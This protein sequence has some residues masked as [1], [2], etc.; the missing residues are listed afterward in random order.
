M[1]NNWKKSLKQILKWR[2]CDHTSKNY[3]NS[4]INYKESSLKLDVTRNL[5]S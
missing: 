3:K 1:L 2:P 5:I 4:M